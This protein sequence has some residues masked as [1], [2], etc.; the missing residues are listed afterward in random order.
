MPAWGQANGGPLTEQEI[1][2]VVVFILT[3]SEEPGQ[4]IS[5][6]STPESIASS[7]RAEWIGLAFGVILFGI[8]ITVM[9]IVQKRK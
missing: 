5:M 7:Q 1:N 8:L 3:F 4:I 2:D 9:I 6:T